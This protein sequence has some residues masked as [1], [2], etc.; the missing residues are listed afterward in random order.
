MR[1]YQTA[2]RRST[3]PTPD[4]A[5]SGANGT[6]MREPR[7]RSSRPRSSPESPGSISNCHSPLRF[8]QRGRQA[9][10]PVG[11]GMDENK[12]VE[13][14]DGRVMLNSRD[15]HGSGYRKVAISTDG[16]VT[17]GEV[18]I[19]REL[20]DP[21]NNASIVRAF[22]NAPAGS[23][24]AK[25]LLFSNAAST[26]ARNIGTV[27]MSCDDG[28]T[29]P[30]ARVF[31]TGSMSY[32]TLATL[33]NGNVGLLYEPGSGIRLA[34][35]NLAWLEGLCLGVAAP[36]ATVEKGTTATVD[37]AVEAQGFTATRITGAELAVPAGWAAEVSGA[38]P[39]TLVPGRTATLTANVTVPAEAAGGT[40]PVPVTNS[41]RAGR[42]GRGT[43]TITVPKGPDDV[44][45]RI[46]VSGGELQNPQTDGYQVGDVLRFHY[47]VTNLSDA[48]TTVLPTGNLR[49]LDPAVDAVNCRFR[50]LA[51]RASYTCTFANHVLT[52]ADLD[53]GHFTPVTRW[54]ST[55]GASVS[56]VDHTGERVDL[57]G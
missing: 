48:T 22:P 39:V 27:R 28:E 9:G 10:E 1:R 2:C 12:T 4:A 37:I 25:V 20:P 14:S 17:Y 56:V 18:S 57:T 54:T 36:D 13:L 11:V 47:Q 24:R 49:N 29:W 5:D 50:N 33:P 15:S 3:S 43:I 35:F 44:D 8:S 45:G 51:A 6:R 38:L 41:D 53:A 30:V 34:E 23:A 16:G 55:S 19:D 31:R 52:R 42:T 32:S 21:A 46:T 7:S 26:S 40:Y